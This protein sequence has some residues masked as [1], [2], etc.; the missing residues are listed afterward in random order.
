M[1][2]YSAN[3]VVPAAVRHSTDNLDGHFLC[4]A[5]YVSQPQEAYTHTHTV[6]VSGLPQ[7]GEAAAAVVVVVLGSDKVVC[8]CFILVTQDGPHAFVP[9]R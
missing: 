3:L 6:L 9:R 5:V 2:L 7:L 4:T 1:I 8:A